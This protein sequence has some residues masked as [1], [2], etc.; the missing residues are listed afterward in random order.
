MEKELWLKNCELN[1]RE[2][3]LARGSKDEIY[4][5]YYI[6]GVRWLKSN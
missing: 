3:L 6:L 1:I 2:N 5:N 4:K